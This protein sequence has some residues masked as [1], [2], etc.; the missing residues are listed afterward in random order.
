MTWS[1]LFI[2]PLILTFEDELKK[3]LLI[4]EWI[5]DIS[6]SIEICMGF[7]VADKNNRT[8]FKIAKSYLLGYFIFDVVATIPPMIFME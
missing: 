3:R 6:W 1:T 7:I 5:V 8:F 4:L 2:T